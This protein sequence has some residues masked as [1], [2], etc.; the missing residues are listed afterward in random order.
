MSRKSE[1]EF[2]L[3]RAR[4][5]GARRKSAERVFLDGLIHGGKVDT[6]RKDNIMTR[7]R[8]AHE[9]NKLRAPFLDG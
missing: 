3:F 8:V 5:R 7:S 9:I 2:S 1:Q 4:F 6:W